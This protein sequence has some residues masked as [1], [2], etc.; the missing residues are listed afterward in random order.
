MINASDSDNL[1]ILIVKNRNALPNGFGS[2][3]RV[4]IP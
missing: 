1:T 2:S 4:I 3:F